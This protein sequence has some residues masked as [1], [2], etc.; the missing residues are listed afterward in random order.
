MRVLTSD[1]LDVTDPDALRRLM[2]L[3]EQGAQVRIFECAGGSFHLKA[4]LFAGQDEQGRLRGQ[5]FIG[6]S[7]ISRQ[8]LLEGLEWN[9]RIDYPGDAGFLE[10]RSR[11]EE[12]FA[13]PRALPLSH[14][15]IDAY[16]AR[17]APPPRAVA[18]GSQELEPLPEPTAVQREA[19]K[20]TPFKVFA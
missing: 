20:A 4:Y 13:Q 18:P 19:L 16:E 17:R 11:F 8:A 15:W 1:Y 2:L 12:L 3:Q 5:A 6:S 7:N 9:Y 14:A 10:A